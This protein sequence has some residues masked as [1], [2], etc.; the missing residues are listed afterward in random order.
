MKGTSEDERGAQRRRKL[1]AVALFEWQALY[2]MVWTEPPTVEMVAAV[3]ADLLAFMTEKPEGVV[4]LVVVEHGSDPPRPEAVKLVRDFF[5]RH[6]SGVRGFATVIDGAGFI[7]AAVV[8][9]ARAIVAARRE[10]FPQRVCR[11][12]GEAADF[13]LSRPVF[14][15]PEQR[16]LLERVIA[17]ARFDARADWE[18]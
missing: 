9:A 8:A 10:S 4:I 12:V 7:A 15:A 13:I 5:A 3:N 6:G 17:D 11:S 2:L 14:E 18:P 16:R 1:R